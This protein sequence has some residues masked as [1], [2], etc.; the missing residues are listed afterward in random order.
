M[1][2]SNIKRATYLLDTC[3]GVDYDEATDSSETHWKKNN[4]HHKLFGIDE[5][6]N[7][8]NILLLREC[9]SQEFNLIK[10]N[11]C[12]DAL[13]RE[14]DKIVVANI[15]VDIYDATRDALLKV[16]ERM[17]TGGIIICED[18]PSTPGL[19]GAYYAMEKFLATPSGKKYMK[20]HL[21]GQY[22]LIKMCD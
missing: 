14:I 17:V 22:F 19:I 7:Y 15:D 5:T 21:C 2:H 8:L 16:S 3:D 9:P 18:P 20:L 6:M 10:S 12:S 4:D 13:P 1:K 11:I